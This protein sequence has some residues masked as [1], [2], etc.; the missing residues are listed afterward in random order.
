MRANN[1][2]KIFVFIGLL[3][4][5]IGEELDFDLGADA[6]V[7]DVVDGVEDGHVDMAV[8]VDFLH[9]LGA[10]VALGYHL[11]L[12]LC[13]LDGVALANHGAEGAVAREVAVAGDEQVAHVDAVSNVALHGVDDLQEPRHLLHGIGHE[14]GLEVVAEL[15]SVADAGGNGVDV[16]QH[17]GVL[18]A[19]DVGRG[20][21]L[22]EVAGQDIGKGLRLVA[23]CTA[24][25]EVGEAFEGDFLGVRG[26]ADAGEILVRHVV[27]LM[28]IFRADEVLVGHDTLDC[29]DD[30]LVAQ[31]DLQFLQVSLQVGRGGDEHQCVVLLGNLVEVA[32]EEYLVNVETYAHKVGGV[33]AQTTEIVDAVVASHIPSNVV[34]LSHHDL[35]YRCCPRPATDNRYASAIIHTLLRF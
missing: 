31:A 16:L 1:N 12:D 20:L 14:D 22:D 33:V 11:H 32:G 34:S 27:D 18:D 7:E 8:A 19:D 24:H 15:Q 30:V 29:G 23:V 17:A 10:E 9:A 28:E 26:S 2:V 35:G 6:L 13:A 3:S 4:E 21:G 5:G 25:G